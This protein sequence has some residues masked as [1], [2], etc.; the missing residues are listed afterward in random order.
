ME[1]EKSVVDDGRNQHG[2]PRGYHFVPQD[3]E[4]IRFLKAK[5]NGRPLPYPLPNIFLDVRFRNFHP[6]ELYE[7]YKGHEEAGYIY[8]FDCREFPT[9]RGGKPKPVRATKNGVWKASGGGKALTTMKHGGAV[10]GYKLTL[11]FYL[12]KYPG[13][14]DPDKTEWGLNEYS[15]ITEPN[16]KDTDWA[17]YRLYKLNKGKEKKNKGS[18]A[19][20][21]KTGTPKVEELPSPGST[22]MASVAST[23][24]AQAEASARQPHYCHGYEFGAPSSAPGPSSWVTP[25]AATNPT[26]Q[27]QGGVHA[28]FMA[29][30]G[31][32]APTTYPTT[33]PQQKVVNH[34]EFADWDNALQMARVARDLSMA[35]AAPAHD[36][37]MAQQQAAEHLGYPETAEPNEQPLKMLPPAPLPAPAAE[38]YL[39]E[40]FTEWCQT[41]Q[42]QQQQQEDPE[43]ECSWFPMTGD[44][45]MLTD[46]PML[47]DDDD[48]LFSC[49][50]DE[51][52]HGTDNEAWPEDVGGERG[53]VDSD[54]QF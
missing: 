38:G 3:I 10:V 34:S 51:L 1:I 31:S 35:L 20:S 28:G 22:S 40:E 46:L 12:K 8:F 18:V 45:F 23:S 27:L 48:D 9:R 26:S 54:E 11:V 52:L 44:D 17:L 30:T 16:N 14:K 37:P 53:K 41:K 50:F 4:L 13:D 33:S 2:F 43:A 7:M 6:A 39:A 47:M 32:P 21:S 36:L 42:Q 19:T 15:W 25:G 5:L 29:L 24:Q 49:T